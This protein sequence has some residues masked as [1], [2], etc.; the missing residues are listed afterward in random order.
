[1]TQP[2]SNSGAEFIAP[3]GGV[4]HDTAHDV[5]T[6][7]VEMLRDLP[8]DRDALVG[9]LTDVGVRGVPSSGDRCVLAEYVRSV[10]WPEDDIELLISSGVL[11]VSKGDTEHLWAMPRH[12]K[13]FTD[14]YDNNEYPALSYADSGAEE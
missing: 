9:L 10:T 2:C 1:M 3:A 11:Y 12:L 14:A 13:D 4:A 8:E 7:A 6:T 5:F